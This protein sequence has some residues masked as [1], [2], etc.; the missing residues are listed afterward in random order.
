MSQIDKNPS[1]APQRP[2][3][4]RLRREIATVREMMLTVHY[5]AESSWLLAA[6]EFPGIC[7]SPAGQQAL[8]SAATIAWQFGFPAVAHWVNREILSRS[9][10]PAASKASDDP[11][12]W[13]DP[14]I[15]PA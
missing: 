4:D 1:A 2:I 5:F 8:R 12:I 3:S 9:A 7:N 11:E 13:Q 6:V 10:D 14:A 15:E